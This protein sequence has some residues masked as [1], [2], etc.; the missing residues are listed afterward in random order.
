MEPAD[1]VVEALKLEPRTRAEI[2]RQLL[3]SLDELSEAEVEEVWLDEAD[4]RDAAVESG[5][6]SSIPAAQV[7]REIRSRIR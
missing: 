6:L 5:Q 3:A 1:L 4:R 2:A 7:F